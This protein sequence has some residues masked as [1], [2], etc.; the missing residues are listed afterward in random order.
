M[1]IPDQ[2]AP[3]DGQETITSDDGVSQYWVDDARY[4]YA[5]HRELERDGRTGPYRQWQPTHY[6]L[7]KKRTLAD[8]VE[9]KA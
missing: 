2:Y 8:W 4:I 7:G 9:G 5:R 6:R 1:P 3:P